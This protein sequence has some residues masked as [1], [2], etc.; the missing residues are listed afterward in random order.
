M[1]ESELS[2]RASLHVCRIS[3]VCMRAFGLGLRFFFAHA[4]WADH[5]V[6][7]ERERQ[8]GTTAS[9]ELICKRERNAS[10]CLWC[11]RC[12]VCALCL[13]RPMI[14]RTHVPS[15]WR[16]HAMLRA[17]V[18]LKVFLHVCALCV[19]PRMISP[20]SDLRGVFVLVSVC[21]ATF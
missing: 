20:L 9:L 7:R 11:P 10:S 2:V 5:N 6:C 3:C 19:A 14:S 13:V 15:L 16:E 1:R 17:T 18:V 4:L 12:F 8:F 21:S